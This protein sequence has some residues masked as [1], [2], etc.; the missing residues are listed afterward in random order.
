MSNASW[1]SLGD[2]SGYSGEELALFRIECGFCGEEG[3]FER[4][5]RSTHT[6]KARNKSLHYDIYKC[7]GCGNLTAVLWASGGSVHDYYQLPPPVRTKTFPKHWPADVGRYWLQAKRSLESE[8]WDAAAVMAGSALQLLLRR[9]NAV[10]GTLLKEIDDLAQKGS[11]PPIVREWA[12][13]LRILRND[14]AHPTPDSN[15]TQE[16]DAKQVVR[17]LRTLLTLL[18]D[19]PDEIGRYRGDKS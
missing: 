5:H 4:E 17:F 9:Q 11:I 7:N 15:G 6:S 13:E 19:L 2:D 8:N 18:V 16:K 14:A 12:H 10:G 1:W 3:N